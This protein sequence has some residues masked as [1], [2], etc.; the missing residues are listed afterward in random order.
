MSV[1]ATFW[2]SEVLTMA[3]DQSPEPEPFLF[4]KT[5][6]RNTVILQ[7]VTGRFR[8]LDITDIVLGKV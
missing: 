8:F 1:G 3:K 4:A 5:I 7:A 6:S 2:R